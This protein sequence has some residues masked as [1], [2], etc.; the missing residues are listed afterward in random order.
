MKFLSPLALAVAGALLAAGGW[1]T[2]V[3]VHQRSEALTQQ[4]ETA[5]QAEADRLPLELR[6]RLDQAL[7]ALQALRGLV[8]GS[9]AVSHVEFDRFVAL[10]GFDQAAAGVQGLAYLP[11]P[12]G[13][14]R[15]WVIR[16]ATARELIGQDLAADA[17]QREALDRAAAADQAVLGPTWQAGPQRSAWWLTLPVYAS[18]EARADPQRRRAE[19]VGWALALMDPRALLEAVDPGQRHVAMTEVLAG[20]DGL[21]WGSPAWTQTEQRRAHRTVHL[22]GRTFQLDLQ[23]EARP[24]P[25][26]EHSLRQLAIRGGLA[27]LALA[28][29]GAALTQ[30]HVMRRA[31]QQQRQRERARLSMVAQRTTNAVM[32]TDNARRIRWVNEAFTTLYGHS[33]AEALG[34]TPAELLGSGHSTPEALAQLEDAYARHVACKVELVNRTRDGRLVW[35]HTELMPMTLRDGRLDGFVEITLD[36]SA[37]KDSARQL[38]AAMREHQGLLNTIREHAIVSVSDPEGRLVDVNDAFCRISGYQRDELLGQSHRLLNAGHHSPAFWRGLWTTVNAGRPWRGEVCNRAKDGSLYWVDSI[39]APFVG[40]DGRLERM[41]S[42]RTDITA[43]KRLEQS[44]RDSRR[45]LDQVGRVA[46]VGGW[47]L[48]LQPLALELSERLRALTGLPTD[49]PVSLRQALRRLAPWARYALL[50]A[51][52][53]GLDTGAGWDLELPLH[54]L[55]EARWLRIVGEAMTDDDGQVRRWVGAV[56]DVTRQ[57]ELQHGLR[58]S[59]E[60]LRGLIEHLPLGLALFDAERQLRTHNQ[61]FADAVLADPLWLEQ[62]GRLLEDVVRQ[63]GQRDGSA[64]EHIEARVTQA[65]RRHQ[66]RRRETF[67][68]HRQGLSYEVTSAPMPDG[69]L[70]LI[71]ADITERRHREAQVLRAEALL[72]TAMDTLDEGFVL[73]DP[74]DRLVLC[75]EPYRRMFSTSADLIVEG[76]SFEEIIRGGALRGQYAAAI[77]RVDEWVAERMRAHRSAGHEIVMKL[78]DGRW[79]RVIERRM[80][81]GHTVGFRIDI[82]ELVEARERAEAGSRIKGEF[83]ANMSH[84]VR[85]PLNAV[86]GMLRLLRRTA[87]N[88]RQLDYVAKSEG[89]ARTLLALLNDILDASK[90]EAGR[91]V[92]DPQPF[93]PVHLLQDLSLLLNGQLH[94]ERPVR[95]RLEGADGLPPWLLGDA[96]RLMQV[97]MNLGGNAIKFTERGEVLVGMRAVG[98]E[99]AGLRVA[100]EV[101]DTGIGIAPEHQ[102]TIFSSFGQAETSTTRRYGGT[103]LGL[104]ISSQLVQMMGGTLRL[105]SAPGRGSRFHFELV[106]PHAEPGSDQAAWRRLTDS[107]LTAPVRPGGPRRLR[108]MRILLVE[109]NA[110]NRQ[111]ACELLEDEGAQVDCAEDGQQALDRADSADYHA[112]LM[113]VRMPVMDGLEA[114]RALRQR[115]AHAH[116]PIIAMSANVSEADRAEALDAGMDDHVGKPFD[117]DA[118]VRCLQR[119]TGWEDDEGDTATVNPPS[120]I[121]PAVL[122]QARA[123]EIDLARALERVLHRTEVWARMARQFADGVPALAERLAS[124]WQAADHAGLARELHS[125]KGLAGMLGATPLAEA[126]GAAERQ[127]DGRAPEAPDAVLARLGPAAQALRSLAEQLDRAEP[128]A[129]ANDVWP[130]LDAPA[131][132]TLLARLQAHLA[133]HDMAATELHQQLQTLA[134][135]MPAALATPLAQ[136]M[137][138]LDF[139]EAGRAL[140]A[141]I[142]ALDTAVA[143]SEPTLLEAAP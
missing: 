48:T 89:A 3:V 61:A 83:L 18:G 45:F 96:M 113:D 33:A 27:S 28:L 26:A 122:A 133:E 94:D 19:V 77:G 7:P 140:E 124:L 134:P 115:P 29:I 57:R 49:R 74:E 2:Q 136:A 79:L 112:V 80:P 52:R 36:L 31:A 50:Q 47:S 141:I 114:T 42:I 106:L 132:R 58:R 88:T 75:N 14:G 60:V 35:V 119:W 101:T 30:M 5:F 91:M 90:I 56:Q 73:Y 126:A 43:A 16:W 41:V 70:V 55:R 123:A 109:D 116:R 8:A 11:R 107:A 20:R 95:L 111:V 103:G 63:A 130:P 68:L 32:M 139:A 82:T 128:K 6:Q 22:A 84:E 85:T 38:A 125:L 21:R 129:A 108:G 64:A 142:G 65:C 23:A 131:L 117:L 34:R 40:A 135:A 25:E 138:R 76:A 97:L 44:L 4:A 104:A 62:P 24:A 37:Q 93:Q 13:P 17:S 100:F 120:S 53:R 9:D 98:E 118:L 54:N 143:A 105:D 59:H 78:D 10:S 46:G 127:Q 66:E 92:L 121:D 51:V 110:N 87:L 86:L 69:G 67:E 72:R 71:Y 81:D 1:V 137:A 39:V 15:P 99:A 102:A 12:E